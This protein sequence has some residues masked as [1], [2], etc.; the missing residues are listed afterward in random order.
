[1]NTDDSAWTAVA[2]SST[3][4]LRVQGD[5]GGL[6]GER[7]GLPGRRLA[8]EARQPLLQLSIV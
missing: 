6:L 8:A 5:R 4:A 7:L 3:D 1:M 2:S